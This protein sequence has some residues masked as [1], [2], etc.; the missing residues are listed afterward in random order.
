MFAPS[1]VFKSSASLFFITLLC[2]VLPKMSQ[3]ASLA[4]LARFT[5]ATAGD[6]AGYSVTKAG[7]VDGDGYDDILIAAPYNDDNGT[8]AGAVYLIYGRS[9]GFSSTVSLSGK[10][11][12]TGEAAGDTAGASVAAAG[13]V[14]GDGY[15]DFL[16]GAPFNDDGGLNSGAAYLVYGKSNRYSGTQSLSPDSYA[17]VVEFT[18][19]AA[20]NQLGF[21]VSGAGD[22]DGDGKS[23][24]MMGAP[25]NS[26]V[27]T[28]A[29]SAYVVYG[30]TAK[31]TSTHSLDN[32]DSTYMN[33]TTLELTGVAIS[34]H[35]G[36]SMSGVGDV[37]GD[38][39]ADFLIGSPARYNS[40]GTNRP[41]G[42][43]LS[44]GG[45]RVLGTQSLSSSIIFIG[46]NNSDYAGSSVAA[47]GD[48]ND[49]GYTDF[50]VGARD[51]DDGGNSSTGAA[52]L[53]YGL[54]HSRYAGTYDLGTMAQFSGS[55][56]YDSLGLGLSG[57]G[58][59]DNDGY[60]DF[61]IGVPGDDTAGSGAGLA[62]VR[63]G[64]ST[65]YSG[66]VSLTTATKFYG[67][68]TG[69]YAGA[70]V[71]GAG[72]VNGDGYADFLIGAY[73]NDEGGTDAG[74]VYLYIDHDQDGVASA[75]D[76]NDS[77]AT[78]SSNRTY[79]EDLD[80]DGL[81]STV[82]VTACSL[83]APAGAATNSRDANDT[84]YD[85][86]GFS[87]GSADCNDLDSTIHATRTYYLDA[88]HD[89]LGSATSSTTVCSLTA[90]TG[91]VRNHLDTNDSVYNSG[92]DSDGDGVDSA[93]DCDDEDAT[94]STEHTY[95]QDTDGD[96]LGSSTVTA[97]LCSAVT[98]TGYSSNN[99]DN[100]DAD[101]DNDGTATT[102]DCDDRDSTVFINQTY[103]QDLDGD[104][105]G[106]DVTT[107]VCTLIPPTDYVTNS[108]D[109]DDEIINTGVDGDGD[110]VVSTSDCDD[111][112]NTVSVNQ[113]YYQDLDGDGFGS[114]TSLSICKS[115]APAGYVNNNIDCN[116]ASSAIL[117]GNVF[118]QDADGDTFG[119]IAVSSL[120]CT[121]A[122]APAGY[123][124]NSTDDDDTTF[125][126]IDFAIINSDGT[127]TITYVNT[128]T[129]IINPFS[130]TNDHF[131]IAISTDLRRLIVT[132][133]G[134]VQ[135]YRDG[136]KKTSEKISKTKPSYKLVKLK[137]AQ[138]Y[139]SGD[140]I[141]VGTANKTTGKVTVLRLTSGDKLK[142]KSS[143][144]MTLLRK[145]QTPVKLSIATKAKEITVKFDQKSH[146]VKATYTLKKSGK[147]KA[148]A[149]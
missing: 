119:N 14:N 128:A 113:T 16:I 137:I 86:D 93:T 102:S 121:S 20:S 65:A 127:V 140:T 30:R 55:G 24:I 1:R 143:K 49:D 126:D 25:Y 29:G 136:V 141:V 108:N 147:L 4:S 99:T 94:V 129:Q 68:T 112:D 116:D 45:S 75:G 107:T 5:G 135:V 42:A 2:L 111:T 148:V 133:G 72:D 149:A 130:S 47:A 44:Y 63:H 80:G 64:R 19:E 117:G 124:T 15:A 78:I 40:A 51:N 114:T 105:L 11:E 122:V 101:Y 60:S 67:Q 95:Y 46:E 90:P 115:T 59:M 52:Y 118:Y 91:Y 8:D 82:T 131:R 50:F 34:E 3:A 22:V 87:T 100:N 139:T 96:G 79:Y 70:S 109:E 33:S 146:Q 103:Y 17:N 89:G 35:A 23:D 18:G 54:A 66:N 36:Y 61:A 43:Y 73:L 10:P 144:T 85:N 106:S 26:D 57:I 58:D 97:T 39:K 81:G 74:A 145:A 132:N 6:K 69:D 7:D 21:S 76:C 28:E 120:S 84:D 98:P 31:Y 138:L 41:G 104:G 88:D 142:K 13:D 9:S 125:G 92:V 12:F 48:V 110:K 53:V 56:S 37:D 134:S 62:Y 32:G 27:A 38:G 83:T 71:A 77:D 123:V